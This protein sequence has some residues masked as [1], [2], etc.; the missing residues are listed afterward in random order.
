MQE[1]YGWEGLGKVCWTEMGAVEGLAAWVYEGFVVAM[2]GDTVAVEVWLTEIS[3]MIVGAGRT[4][5]EVGKL[6]DAGWA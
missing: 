1:D 4:D 5:Y 2:D 6:G 3:W